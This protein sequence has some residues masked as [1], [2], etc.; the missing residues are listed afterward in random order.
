MW[1]HWTL[2]YS[3][4]DNP[5]SHYS[6]WCADYLQAPMEPPQLVPRPFGCVP[7]PGHI[8]HLHRR[9]IY[10]LSIPWRSLQIASCESSLFCLALS[11][12]PIRSIWSFRLFP[13]FYCYKKNA[14]MNSC[15]LEH[16]PQMP[17]SLRSFCGFSWHW[18]LPHVFFQGQT[19]PP[20]S[21]PSSPSASLGGLC[22]YD[23][24]YRGGTISQ[25]I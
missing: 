21:T 10:T 9:H 4:Y 16:L 23:P 1:A 17:P 5:S 18:P 11:T 13:L 20:C 6:L 25:R 8:F 15:L 3:V 19:E 14:S 12:I 24:P 7:G 2:F 22:Y